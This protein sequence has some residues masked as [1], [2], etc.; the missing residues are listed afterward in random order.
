[1][2]NNIIKSLEQAGI[3]RTSIQEVSECRRGLTLKEQLQHLSTEHPNALAKIKQMQQARGKERYYF[4]VPVFE[5][6]F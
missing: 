1:M 4:E 2:T 3:T 5:Y 6:K